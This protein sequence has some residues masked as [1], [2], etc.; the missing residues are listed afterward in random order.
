[1][2]DLARAMPKS[3]DKLSKIRGLPRPTVEQ[4]GETIVALVTR[5]ASAPTAGVQ[6]L[7][8]HEP[9][10]TERFAADALW[11]AAQAICLNQ[12]I[13]PAAVTSR[14]EIGE[15][16]RH[17]AAGTDPGELRL[18]RTWRREALGEPLLAFWN[19]R[20]PVSLTRA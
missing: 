4:Y 8:G 5:G 6:T 18:M 12:S 2:I 7:R 14:Q 16:H 15:L 19:D 10:P 17:L 1:M 9:T 3:L 20:K 11:A 13:D